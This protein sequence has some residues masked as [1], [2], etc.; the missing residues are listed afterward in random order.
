MLN[1]YYHDFLWVEREKF[2]F[3]CFESWCS[4]KQNKNQCFIKRIAKCLLR[5][6][7]G[8]ENLNEWLIEACLPACLDLRVVVRVLACWMKQTK[9]NPV[10]ELYIIVTDLCMC[11][12]LLMNDGASDVC[13]E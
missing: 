4:A 6:K 11:V 5:I 1:Y 7:T 13:L 2:V 12:K 9:R 10:S 8:H 3:S